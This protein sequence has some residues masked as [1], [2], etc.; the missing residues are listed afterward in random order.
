MNGGCGISGAA[1]ERA[2]NSGAFAMGIRELRRERAV[3]RI[4][5]S[6]F[7]TVT[8]GLIVW[9][10]TSSLSLPSSTIDKVN[11]AT[12]PAIRA[13]DSTNSPPAASPT[14]GGCLP[15]RQAVNLSIPTSTPPTMTGVAPQPKGLPPPNN[16][17][18]GTILLYEDFSHYRADEATDWGPN[19]SV[20]PGLDRRYWLVSNVEGVHPVGRKIRLPNEFGFECRYSAYVPETTH[21]ILGWW[22]EPLSTRIA[23]LN[24]Q[25][26]KYVIEWGIRCG[27]DPTRL[28]PLGSS[29]LC[30]KKYY[31]TVKLP[32]GTG[33]EVGVVQPTGILRIERAGNVVRVSLD[34]QAA[35]A[36][37]MSP[38]GQLVGF[39][40]DVVKT[41]NGTLFFTDFRIAR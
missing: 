6:V 15:P 13:T 41:K 10:V 23:F 20:K 16:V 14:L 8:G 26:V 39:E 19:T 40:M 34:G 30:A 18:V 3:R 12:G 27:N 5:E 21:G 24:D 28:N 25:G 36:G 38:L 22:K 37:S 2:E 35:G 33:N 11:V 17:P 32:D 31:H 1:V 9:S 29:S 7:A 4:W